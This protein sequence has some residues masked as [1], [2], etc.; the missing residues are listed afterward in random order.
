MDESRLREVVG[1]ASSWSEVIRDLGYTEDS[2]SAR[3]TIRRRC[4]DLA[5]DVTHLGTKPPL[6]DD[7]PFS[8]PPARDNLRAA[9]PTLVAA[10]LALRGYAVLW[11]AEPAKF[12]LVAEGD[13]GLVRIQVKSSTWKQD[14]AWACKLTR[15]ERSELGRRRAAY[16]SEEIDFFGCV[17]GDLGVYLIP[18]SLVEG[19]SVIYL[20]KYDA[21][22]LHSRDRLLFPDGV[23]TDGRADSV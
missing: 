20:R 19:L 12:D 2:G 23:E 9:A 10:A 3:A 1:G 13:G 21:F 8:R 22:Q 14:G 6:A 16:S 11:P 7:F 18:V 17:D 4:R 5:I 15:S